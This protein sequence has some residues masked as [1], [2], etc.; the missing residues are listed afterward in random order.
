MSV[1]RCPKAEHLKDFLANNTKGEVSDA[2]IS[3]LYRL[4]PKETPVP[5]M[6]SITLEENE[7]W[8]RAEAYMVNLV[9]PAS[10]G[11][12]IKMAYFRSV[13]DEERSFM[14]GA[15]KEINSMF[16]VIDTNKYFFKILGMALAIGN[17]IN[18]GSNKGQA[19]GYEIAVFMK[20]NSTKDNTG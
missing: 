14:D 20:L 5:E 2:Q 10:L 7:V 12:R 11:E 1:P 17:I 3:L 19:D 9:E 15:I 18:G 8:D 4:W 16:A 13:W 6:S